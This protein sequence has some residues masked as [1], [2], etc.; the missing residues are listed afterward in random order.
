VGIKFTCNP[1]YQELL[2]FAKNI[3]ER[4]NDDATTILDARNVLKKFTVNGS[5]VVVK[6]FKIPNIVNQIVYSFFRDSKASRSYMYSQKLIA[7]GIPTPAPIAFV[8]YREFGLFKQSY[9]LCEHFDFDFEIRDVLNDAHFHNRDQILKAFAN[10]SYTLHQA[11]VYHVDYSPGNVLIK[12]ER[13]AYLFNI[14]DV[15][16]MEF[17]AFTDELRMKNLSRFSATPSDTKKIAEFYATVAGLDATWA[18]ERLEFYHQ[19]H[20]EYRQRKR[21]LKKLRR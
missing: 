17:I 15:N 19:K 8:E 18:V 2:P 4:F 21:E 9:Y 7:L 5:D 16:R 14:V 11:G 1:A 6:S 12:E 3:K 20:Q 10:F 13:G